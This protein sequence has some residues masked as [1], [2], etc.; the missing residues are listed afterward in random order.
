MLND[1]AVNEFTYDWNAVFLRYCDGMAFT[2]NASLP[3][4]L[5]DG[6]TELWLRG[7]E[8]LRATFDS[9]I[10]KHG[11]GDA[12]T[13]NLGGSSAGGHATYLHTDRMAEWV[14]AANTAASKPKASI[15]S[16]PD[17]GKTTPTIYAMLLTTGYSICVK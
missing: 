12:T 11:L 3:L 13:V 15:I 14:Y 8:I 10:A 7:Y 17:S 2:A 1:P 16:M 5:P 9:L 6:S 4:L